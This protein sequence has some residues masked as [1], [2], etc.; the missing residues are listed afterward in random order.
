MVPKEII[1]QINRDTRQTKKTTDPPSTKNRSRKVLAPLKSSVPR[2][3][4]HMIKRQSLVLN[5]LLKMKLHHRA[6]NGLVAKK[7]VVPLLPNYIRQSSKAKPAKS[8]GNSCP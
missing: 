6:E 3:V 8:D 4:F 7:D 2:I 5:S 1:D